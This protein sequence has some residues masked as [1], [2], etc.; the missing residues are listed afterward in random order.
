MEFI[1]HGG[2]YR[3]C[4][5]S[6][7]VIDDKQICYCSHPKPMEMYSTCKSS[8][9]VYFKINALKLHFRFCF[10]G[11]HCLLNSFCSAFFNWWSSTCTAWLSFW[12]CSLC[13]PC[14]RNWHFSKHWSNC[15]RMVKFLPWIQYNLAFYATYGYWTYKCN[16]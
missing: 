15:Y 11:R 8:F 4:C 10:Q 6:V 5:K 1:Q 9:Y 14:V 12:G 2:R 7:W 13:M 3:I 16:W